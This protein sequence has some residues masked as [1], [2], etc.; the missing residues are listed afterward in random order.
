MTPKGV[1]LVV[2]GTMA[3]RGDVPWHA[4]IYY[5]NVTHYDQICGGS[6]ISETV[7]LSG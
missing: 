4:G 2:G 3:M 1:P 6:L 7:V 5:G